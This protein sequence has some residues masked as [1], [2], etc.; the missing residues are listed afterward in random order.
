MTKRKKCKKRK[1]RMMGFCP[2]PL[3]N[4]WTIFFQNSNKKEMKKLEARGL[5]FHKV[6]IREL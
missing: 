1:F 2:T 3:E 5:W 6:E 4:G